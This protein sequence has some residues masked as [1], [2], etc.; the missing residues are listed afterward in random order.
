VAIGYS[1]KAEGILCD[2]FELEQ[3]KSGLL[4]PIK[5]FLDEK[6]AC[7]KVRRAWEMRAAV[8]TRLQQKLPEV[9]RRSGLTF[10]LIAKAVTQKDTKRR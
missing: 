3:V 9:Q 8:K 2:L 7:E 1:V 6:I 10:D 4:L 5:D